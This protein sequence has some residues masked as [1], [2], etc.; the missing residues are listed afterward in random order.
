M[1]FKF[2]QSNKGEGERMKAREK[3]GVKMREWVKKHEE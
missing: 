1:N 2:H 3:G